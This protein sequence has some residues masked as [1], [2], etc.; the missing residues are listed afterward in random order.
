MNEK[1]EMGVEYILYYFVFLIF[2][3]F[4][5]MEILFPALLKG[6]TDESEEVNVELSICTQ[7]HS[8]VKSGPLLTPSTSF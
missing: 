4:Q 1:V 6:L 7:Y 2:Q 5:N 8:E 3:T